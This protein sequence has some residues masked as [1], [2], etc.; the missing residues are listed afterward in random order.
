MSEKKTYD[1]IDALHRMKHEGKKMKYNNTPGHYTVEG[2]DL[3]YTDCEV[4]RPV[5]KDGI[6]NWGR[7]KWTD[8]I[9]PFNWKKLKPG[10]KFYYTSPH[11]DRVAAYFVAINP[12]REEGDIVTCNES[13][14]LYC[15]NK[16][17]LRTASLSIY[18]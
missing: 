10:D 7:G 13:G 16:H 14:G 18:E 6:F 8:Y 2:C 9:E 17:Y 4:A 5:G 12:R 15:Y 11:G 3:T 1:F